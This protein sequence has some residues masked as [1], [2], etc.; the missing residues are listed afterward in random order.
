MA[1]E[2]VD[3]ILEA[4]LKWGF[5][6]QRLFAEFDILTSRG[7]QERFL[8]ATKKRQATFLRPAFC[9]VSEELTGVSEELTGVSEELTGV[10]SAE[11]PQG[12]G[13]GVGNSPETNAK[14]SYC[15][16]NLELTPHSKVKYSKAKNTNQDLPHT[17]TQSTRARAPGE[18]P[19]PDVELY[20]KGKFFVVPKAEAEEFSREHGRA[21]L[22]YYIGA[23]NDFIGK[24]RIPADERPDPLATISDWR[25]RDE[26]EGKFFYSPNAKKTKAPARIVRE[27]VSHSDA[28]AALKT[29]EGGRR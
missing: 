26:A 15:G 11:T 27:S 16:G 14:A 18:E 22:A 8:F 1:L 2:Q 17:H 10:N 13:F 20:A 24:K 28:A 5:F 23:F 12:A 3:T 7:I 6:D 4:A 29:I 21:C 19:D 25:R 9:L